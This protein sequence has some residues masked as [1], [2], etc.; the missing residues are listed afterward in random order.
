MATAEGWVSA[1]EACSILGIR[2]QTLYAYVSRGVL[3]PRREG[4]RSYFSVAELEQL[5]VRGKRSVR[6]GR[7]DV[8]I[9]SAVTLVDPDGRLFYRGQNVATIATTWSFER[10]AEWLWSGQDNGEP[11]HWPASEELKLPGRSLPERLRG[12]VARLSVSAPDVDL[13]PEAAMTIGRR[14]LPQLV[15]ALPL[16]GQPAKSVRTPLSNQLWPRLSALP[17]TPARLAALNCGLIVFADHELVPSTIAAR[18]AASAKA[19]PLDAVLAAMATH[20]GVARHGFRTAMEDALNSGSE[21]LGAYDHAMYRERD[22]RADVLVPLIK[23]ASART[24]WRRV[25][26]ALTDDRPPTADLAIAALSVACEM[27][28]TAAEAI[29]SLARVAGLLAHVGEE[30]EHPSMF[31]P[32]AGYRGPAPSDAGLSGPTS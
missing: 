26:I 18:V 19:P 20:A 7:V 1:A 14:V 29:Y 5:E 2:S 21:P 25:E 31:R 4:R 17:A 9:D 24:G 3:G 23:A 27:T 13:Q 32:R 15:A 8:S 12:A 16:L 11:R 30:Y 28:P 10:T 6:P 22:P